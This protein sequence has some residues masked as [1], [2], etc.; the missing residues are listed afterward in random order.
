M[1]RPRS[2][3][4]RLLFS[5]GSMAAAIPATDIHMRGAW[6]GNQGY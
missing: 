2:G 1:T 5:D 3:L 6:R 4:L